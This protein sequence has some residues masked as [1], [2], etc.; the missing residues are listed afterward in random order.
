M[1]VHFKSSCKFCR[2]LLLQV[3][4]RFSTL[5]TINIHVIIFS[6]FLLYLGKQLTNQQITLGNKLLVYI[7]CCLAGRGYP[8]GDVPPDQVQVVKQR[9]FQ[10]VTCQHS[11]NAKDSEPAY[12]Y[13]RWKK[14][15]GS[16]DVFPLCTPMLVNSCF[17]L[18]SEIFRVLL[19]F[20]T[21]EFLNVLALA[22]EEPEFT[23]ELGLRRRQLVVDILLQLVVKEEGFSVSTL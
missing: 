11:L 19:Q 10:C 2:V 15:L 21:R 7:S 8:F 22:F 17:N 5:V 16:V 12:P 9:V 13:L 3:R 1:S 23:S 6:K 14:I 4:H 18:L 20:D